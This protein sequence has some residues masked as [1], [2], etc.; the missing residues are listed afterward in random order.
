MIQQAVQPASTAYGTLVTPPYPSPG[1]SRSLTDKGQPQRLDDTNAAPEK[2]SENSAASSMVGAWREWDGVV[3][4]DA[5]G[6]ITFCSRAAIEML[7][8]S[9]D[10]LMGQ[11][12][13][14]LLPEIPLR[15]YTPEFNLAYV[16][17]IGGHG[18]WQRRSLLTRN[19]KSVSIDVS[20]SIGHS[21]LNDIERRSI[22][23]ILMDSERTVSR[24]RRAYVPINR[25]FVSDTTVVSGTGQRVKASPVPA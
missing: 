7:G 3:L 1:V 5:C 18:V 23:L 11:P 22:V 2:V 21:M 25:N 6:H 14:S 13:T 20:L 16:R 19:G 8:R 12:V 24:A 10:E 9:R 17:T 4:L 15:R